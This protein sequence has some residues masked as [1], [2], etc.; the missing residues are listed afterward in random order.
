MTG[1]YRVD[2]GAV[3]DVVARLTGFEGHVIEQLDALEARVERLRG[4]WDGIGA[5]GYTD[6]QRE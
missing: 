6:A 4:F 2:L 1:A 5:D 3:D